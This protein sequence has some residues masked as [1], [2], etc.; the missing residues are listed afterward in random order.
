MVFV[1]SIMGIDRVRNCGRYPSTFIKINVH[2]R[3]PPD[4]PQ[5]EHLCHSFHILNKHG[6]QREGTLIHGVRILVKI[7]TQEALSNVE[8]IQEVATISPT[9]YHNLYS[10]TFGDCALLLASSISC[11]VVRSTSGEYVNADLIPQIF[12]L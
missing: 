1:N 6:Q 9:E 5:S 7:R 8:C 4:H 12:K 11:V 3:P 10:C 2:L